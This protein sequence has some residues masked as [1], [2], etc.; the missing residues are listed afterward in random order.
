MYK[1]TLTALVTAAIL[2]IGVGVSVES[3]RTYAGVLS[4][5]TIQPRKQERTKQVSIIVRKPDI[6]ALAGKDIVV[7]IDRSGSMATV[8]CP[9]GNRRSGHLTRWQWCQEQARELTT[10]AKHVISRG[11]S[12]VLFSALPNKRYDNVTVENV[13]EIFRKNRPWGSTN[14]ALAVKRQ[15]HDY[16]QRRMRPEKY[17][18]P[19]KPLLIAVITD[20]MFHNLDDIQKAIVD[21]S[22]RVNSP[23]DIQIA[24]LQ[25]G[26]DTRGSATIKTLDK[27]E[28][29]YSSPRY[30]IVHAK[31]FSELQNEGLI[32]AL[33][34]MVTD[35]K[36]GISVETRKAI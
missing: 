33:V 36:P 22:E 32:G 26:D 34:D 35:D 3:S 8:D 31:S 13:S 11:L 18:G 1:A 20:G 10:R 29:W 16:Y 2:L 14:V 28:K 15:L 23:Q 30:D 21:A 12:I 27:P 19:P 7:L 17:G 24:F 25:I 9:A 5:L 4:E 6:Q